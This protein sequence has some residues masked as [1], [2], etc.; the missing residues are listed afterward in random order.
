MPGRAR[1]VSCIFIMGN[2]AYFELGL[3]NLDPLLVLDV[4]DVLNDEYVGVILGVVQ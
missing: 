1:V 2:L 4:Q 3:W